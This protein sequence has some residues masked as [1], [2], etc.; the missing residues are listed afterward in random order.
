MLKKIG[1]AVL[2]LI[3]AIGGAL[4]WLRGNMDGLVK[5]AIEKYGSEMTKAPVKVASVEIKPADGRGIIR[6]LSIGNPAGFKTD[7]ALN[8]AVIDV[9]IDIATVAK[10]VVTIRKIEIVAPDIIYEKGDAQTNF[11]ALQRN[12]AGYVGPAEKKDNSG[13]KKL[14]VTELVVR[15]AKANANA[16]FMGDT[17]V[18]VGLPN[19]AL[20]DLG[21][22]KGGVTGGELGQEIVNALKQ[23]LSRSFSFDNLS[24]SAVRAQEKAAS[25][26]KGL[27]GK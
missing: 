26:I 19:I 8:V 11:D 16:A 5:N 24:K 6:G 9:D 22:A 2:L 10:D 12:I 17:K 13:G 25:A 23:Q 14:I 3:V 18:S 27:F 21:K 20:H 15:D 4:F 1:I 7:H